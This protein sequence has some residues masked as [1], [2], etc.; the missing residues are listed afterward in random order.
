MKCDVCSKEMEEDGA[1]LIG[2]SSTFSAETFDTFSVE[3]TQRQLGKYE[4]NKTYNVCWECWL[5]SL[6]VKPP[7]ED[8][9][10]A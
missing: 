8:N 4:I 3:F 2:I 1:S 6:G 10:E 5:K 7:I 9:N